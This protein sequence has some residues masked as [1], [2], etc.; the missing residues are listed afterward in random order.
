MPVDNVCKL[1]SIENVGRERDLRRGV[2]FGKAFP[3]NAR[4]PMSQRHRKQTGLADDLPNSDRLKVCSRRLVDFLEARM[5]E[6]VEFLPVVVADHKG[7]VASAEYSIVHAVDPLDALD[8]A[9]S[10][11]RYS[12]ILKAEIDKV[13]RLVLDPKRIAAGRKVFRLAGF[14]LPLFVEKRL[15][16]EMAA[17]NFVGVEFVPLDEYEP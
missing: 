15:A 10:K 9:A 16:G 4:F 14:R 3:L 11:P 5:L 8:A 2:A 1:D 17:E 7:K 13:E 6:R 12:R